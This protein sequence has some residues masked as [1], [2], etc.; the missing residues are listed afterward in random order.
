V[1]FKTMLNGGESPLLVP[2]TILADS[3]L[4]LQMPVA[5]DES[6]FSST[7]AFGALRQSRLPDACCL[8]LVCLDPALRSIAPPLIA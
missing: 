3:P 6:S 5:G 8:P 1:T 2:P 4:V 7:A